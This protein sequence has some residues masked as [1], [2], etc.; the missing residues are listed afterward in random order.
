MIFHPSILLRCR[1]IPIVD[2]N[3]PQI[4]SLINLMRS[5]M[6]EHDGIGLSA[7]QVGVLQRI[8]I[9]GDDVLINPVIVA[10]SNRKSI[11]VEG[12]LSIPNTFVAVKRW[13]WVDVESVGIRKRYN[14]I[15]S[16]V[17]QHE[18]DH[19]DGRL[20]VDYLRRC[21]D[22]YRRDSQGER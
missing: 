18:I 11:L 1:S 4:R 15:W 14:G 9:V 12:C 8:A 19:M 3:S 22:D 20:I 6:K 17:V 13:E 5:T 16:H 2:H 7:V 21:D 10:V